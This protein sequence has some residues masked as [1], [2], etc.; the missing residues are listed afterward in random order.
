MS[1]EEK[2]NNLFGKN[3]QHLR[4]MHGETLTELGDAVYLGNTAIKNYESGVRDPKPQ[5]LAAL[6]KH[7]GKTVDELLNTDLSELRKMDFKFEGTKAMVELWKVMI[8]LSSSEQALRNVH[9][10]EG[11]AKCC[12]I[13]DSFSNNDSVMGHVFSDCFELFGKAVEE[14]E[15]LEAIA[16]MMWL[17]F[18]N[19]F[20][21][22]DQDMMEAFS[23]VL[24]PR[25]N[26]PHANKVI[27]RAKA[28]VSDEVLNKRKEF[29]ED[30]NDF[31]I[32]MVKALK[33]ESGWSDLGDYF[34]GMKYLV[35]MVDSG[36]SSEMNEAV[37]MQMLL[38]QVQLGN[39][40]AFN[41]LKT[42]LLI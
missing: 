2:H 22:M 37:G 36:L 24:Y 9:F 3:L 40:F 16:N 14:D 6:A 12:A 34:L 42:M 39:E 32:E 23:S 21:I 13:L 5:V 30:L 27:T 17:L 4:E 25:K 41:T 35:G 28:N 38:S 10:K 15:L 8:P 7:Y 26:Q 18:L 11:Y 33:S 1:N 20:Q 31:A 29:I 19:W